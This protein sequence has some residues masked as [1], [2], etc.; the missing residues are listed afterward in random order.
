MAILIAQQPL[1]VQASN[2][3]RR[4]E[5]AL[6][7]GSTCFICCCSCFGLEVTNERSLQKFHPYTLLLQPPLFQFYFNNQAD[8]NESD[9][10]FR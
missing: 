1:D 3:K 8:D 2:F 7:S 9:K 5:H 6:I 4:I 10:T